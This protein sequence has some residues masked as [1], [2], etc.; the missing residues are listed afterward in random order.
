MVRRGDERRRGGCRR[1]EDRRR[2]GLARGRDPERGE[3]PYANARERL[4]STI[5]EAITDVQRGY[6]VGGV[7]LAVPGFIQASEN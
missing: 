7:C 3:L 4:L 5:A 1:N 6:E 2:G